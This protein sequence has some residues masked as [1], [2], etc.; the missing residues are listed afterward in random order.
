MEWPGKASFIAFSALC[1]IFP[2]WKTG[3]R[4]EH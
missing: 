3:T 4:K 2:I 1:F